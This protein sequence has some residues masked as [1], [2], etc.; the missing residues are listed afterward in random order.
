MIWAGDEDR[1]FE[2]SHRTV[3]V[4]HN[5]GYSKYGPPTGRKVVVWAIANCSS[6]ENEFYEEWVLYNNSSLLAPARLRPARARARHRA[7]RT[8]LDPLGD[9]RFGEAERL[10]GPGQAGPAPGRHDGGVRPGGLRARACGTTPGTGATCRRSTAPTRRTSA[11]SGPTDRHLQGRGDLK[12]F[13]LSMLAAFPDLA[14]S[15]DDVYWM[16]NEAD[17]HLVSIRWSAIGTHRGHGVYGAADRPPR[18]AS[19]ASR[20]TASSTGASR[21][22]GRCSTSSRSC[23]RSCATSRSRAR[24]EPRGAPRGRRRRSSRCSRRCRA[25][26]QVESAGHA[27]FDLVVLD[28]EHGPG[29]GFALEEHLR[30]ADAAG[31]PALVRV[32]ARCR[33]TSSPRSTRA[34]PGV[35]VPHVLDAAGRRGGRRRRALPA[36]RAARASRSPPAPAR[37]GAVVA[38]TSTSARGGARPCVVVQIEDARGRRRAPTRSSPSRAS[39]AC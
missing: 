2:T 29:G 18:G 30:A 12:S 9:E 22:S 31:L 33:S 35:V 1:G 38:G 27:G 28:T 7:T 13:V 10:L 17:G 20:S 34:R 4:G 11:G 25:P 32:P 37:Y 24:R 16:G 39:P 6:R 26:A 19:G 3:I 8:H 5:T 23:S 36:A 21:R 15:V 14:L